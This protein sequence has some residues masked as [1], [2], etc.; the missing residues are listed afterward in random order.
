MAY[1]TQE[2]LI[3]LVL[4]GSAAIRLSL[5]IAG[6]IVLLLAIVITSYRQT[7]RAYPSGGGAYIVAHENLGIVAGLLAAASLLVDYVLTVSVSVAASVDA[8]S[9]TWPGTREWAVPVACAL[10]MLVALLNLR[11]VRESGTIFAIPTY[12]FVVLIA[13]TVVGAI[14]KLALNSDL[15]FTPGQADEPVLA[16]QSLTIFL[17]LRAFASGCTALTGV[18][19]ISNGVQ[20]FKQPESRNASQT[21]LAMGLILGSMFFALTFVAWHLGIIAHDDNTVIAQISEFVYGRGILFVTVNLFTAAILV[22]AAN[23][24][25]A[26]FPRLSAILARDGFL[27]RVLHQRGSRLVFT[28][29]IFVLTGLACVLLIVFKANTTRLIP[30]YAL[31]V[32]F[33]FTLSQAGMVLKWRRDREPGWMRAAFVNGLG[34]VATGV[35]FFVVMITKFTGGAW[36]IV[37]LV[38]LLA[39]LCWRIGGF[40]RRVA[41]ELHVPQNAELDL[42]PSGIS[43]AIHVVPVEEINLPTVIA[44]STACSHSSNVVAVHVDFDHED[45]SDNDL[46]VRWKAQFPNIP[47]VI[48]FSPYRAVAEPLSWYISDRVRDEFT[49]EA[50]I[51][52]PSVRPRR[53]WQR[54][55]VNQS[56]RRLRTLLAARK[57][58]SFI[59]QPFPIR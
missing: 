31:G 12:G 8:L 36:A 7:V 52:F 49:H 9:S 59:E 1:A 47:L 19:A 4:A 55:L 39:Y 14:V 25:F 48:I 20:A 24:A 16:T 26:D 23:T 22:L 28:Y 5:P 30:L 15:A 43:K 11:G 42:V 44:L 18:E 21:L 27:P 3:I 41:R 57:S 29:G 37:I 6:A 51:I 40:Y 35:V 45:E 2:I 32:F 54:P 34:A 38:P 53:W 33:S 46:A 58:V 56:M 17:V 10:V 50:V 13:V